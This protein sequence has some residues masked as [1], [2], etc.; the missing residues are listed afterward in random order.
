[1]LLKIPFYEEF[2]KTFFKVLIF[3]ESLIFFGIILVFSF[4]VGQEQFIGKVTFPVGD[5]SV[6]RK[7]PG[8]AWEKVKL[9]SLIYSGDKL[10]TAK[11][12]RCEV[13]LNDGSIIRIGESTTFEFTQ[14]VVTEK[15][16]NAQSKLGAGKVWANITKLA[17]KDEQFKVN[18]PSAVIAIRG[19]V[20]NAEVGSDSSTTTAVYEGEVEVGWKPG[21]VKGPVW[22]PRPVEGPK[23][24]T[25]KEWFE[26]VKAQQKISVKP[27]G[28]YSK[29][30]FD[31]AKEEADNE[32]VKWNKERDRALGR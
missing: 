12:S 17:G 21:A 2:M 3:L 6:Q 29:S 9:G 15:S 10:K 19:T 32:W 22:P 16:K 7:N 1:V 23:Q 31:P 18:A 24:I 30:D 13:M 14:A 11:E 27:D 8:T 20:F 26:I 5:V 4:L 25:M 28:T